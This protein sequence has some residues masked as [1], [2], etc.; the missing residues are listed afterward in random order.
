MLNAYTR[1]S[2]AVIGFLARLEAGMEAGEE[3]TEIKVAEELL[4][5]RKEQK[6]FQMNSF[7][8]ISAMVSR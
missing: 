8:T 4:K 5:S 2:A 1:D 6:Y 3:W 7:G